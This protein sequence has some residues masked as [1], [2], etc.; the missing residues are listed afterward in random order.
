MPFCFSETSLK[1][2]NGVHPDL[3]RVMKR[4]IVLSPVDFKIT[5][6]LRTVQRQTQLVAAGAYAVKQAALDVTVMVE[7]GGDWKHFKDG[8]HFQLPHRIYPA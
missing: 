5:E 3:V 4:A 6:G 8:P 7:W 2:F 1:K